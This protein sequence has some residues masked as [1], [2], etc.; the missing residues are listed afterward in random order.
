M[1]FPLVPIIMGAVSLASSIIASRSSKKQAERTANANME[2]AKYQAGVNEAFI[3]KQNVYNTPANQMSRFGEA[4]LNP[5]LI[6]GQGNAGNQAQPARYEAPRVDYHFNP[7]Q[8]PEVLSPFQDYRMREAQIDSVKAQTE[9]T[10]TEIGNKLLARL[11]TQV[12]T[13]KK[14]FD[15]QQSKVLAPYQ[16]DIKHGEAQAAYT[17]LMQEFAR[18]DGMKLENALKSEQVKQAPIRTEIME[19]ERLFN[20]YRNQWMKMGVTTSDHFIIRAI[21]R[22]LGQDTINLPPLLRK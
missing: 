20:Q 9:S 6:Y 21:A 4:G 22:A 5:N 8:I 16:A 14:E 15:L 19:T 10:R 1:P 18:L 13:S 17:K 12:Q 7:L 2:L 11:L 3:D